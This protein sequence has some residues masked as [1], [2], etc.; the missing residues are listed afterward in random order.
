[1]LNR[2]LGAHENI[3]GMNELHYFGDIWNPADNK[4]L[5][6]EDAVRLA[7]WILA[8]QV[9]GIWGKKPGLVE[10]Q[11]AE[12]LLRALSGDVTGMDVYAHVVASFATQ[13]GKRIACEQTPRNVFYAGHILEKQKNAKVIQLIRD[14]RAVIASQKNRWKRKKLGGTNTPW[15]EVVRVWMNYHPYTMTKLWMKAANAGEALKGHGVG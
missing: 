8:R 4:P 11:K 6:D 12:E 2:V 13:A 1:M 10:T 5:N 15:S 3:L 14:P 9:N 7:S